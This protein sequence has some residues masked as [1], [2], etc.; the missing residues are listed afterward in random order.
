MILLDTDHCVFFPRGRTEVRAAFESHG[1]EEPGI[2]IITVG[3]L[4]FGAQRSAGPERNRKTCQEFIDR[5]TVVPLDQPIMLRFAQ[6]KA[7]LASRGEIVEDP[8]LLIAATA[9][10]HEVPL[11]THNASHFSRIDGLRLEDWCS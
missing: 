4:Y 2:S 3:E 9:L 1:A 10:E 5:V 6:I 8:D 7:I 11:V